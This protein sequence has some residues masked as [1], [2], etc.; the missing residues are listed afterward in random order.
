MEYIR[1]TVLRDA[2][3]E[4][5][6]IGEI[7]GA[8]LT[9]CDLTGAS[10]RRAVISGSRLVDCRLASCDIQAATMSRSTF[11]RCDF[12][13]ANLRL[14]ILDGAR[15]IQCAFTR[16]QMSVL[17][18][19][20]PWFQGCTFDYARGADLFRGPW[21]RPEVEAAAIRDRDRRRLAASRDDV[22]T[23]LL[24]IAGGPSLDGPSM[25]GAG[26]QGTT[27]AREYI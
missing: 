26:S 23:A 11:V 9:G 22:V 24:G 5:V 14:A 21:D 16:A 25:Y 18:Q 19:H 3:L 27:C 1:G 6:R 12:S 20:V 7:V 8:P 13:G 10:L 15:F 2:H 17:R 4:G